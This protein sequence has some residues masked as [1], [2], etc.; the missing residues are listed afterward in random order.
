MTDNELGLKKWEN[1]L[2]NLQANQIQTFENIKG[3]EKKVNHYTQIIKLEKE[4]LDINTI[5]ISRAK[6]VISK[7]K[8]DLKKEPKK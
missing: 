5:S 1:Y 7:I 3:A 8:K 2:K 6:N 4:F